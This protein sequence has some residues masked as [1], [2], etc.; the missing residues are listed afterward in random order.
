MSAPLRFGILGAARI[1]PA[2]LVYPSEGRSDVRLVVV[3]ARDR[4]RAEAFAAEHRIERVADDY[5]AVVE[6]PEIDAVYVPLPATA[7]LAWARAALEAGKHVLCEK[8][9]VANA[10][11]ARELAAVA[12]ASGRVLMEAFHYRYHPLFARVQALLADGAAGRVTHLAAHFAVPHVPP[13]DIRLT[14]ETGGGALMDLGCYCVH[15]LR[16][17]TGREPVVES[18]RAELG[19][20]EVDVA[21]EGNLRFPGPDGPTG[22]VSCSLRPEDPL[23]ARLAIEGTEGRMTVTNPVAPQIGHELHLVNADGE[24]REQVD[25]TPSYTYQL[26]A[27]LGAVRDGAPVPTDGADAVATLTVIDALYAAAGLHRR[28]AAATP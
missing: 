25:R 22:A 17:L 21:L 8:P 20:P 24:L 26:E 7:H 28:G 27:F 13:G 14:L 23:A 2:A 15:M 19:P 1:T 12:D 6:D 3:G 4:A 11:E 18:A 10:A 16:H 5:R 9:L